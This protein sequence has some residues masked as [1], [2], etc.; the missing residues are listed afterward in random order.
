MQKAMSV[1]F[2]PGTRN[3]ITE[4][5]PSSASNV[6]L[7]YPSAPA[8]LN[9][10]IGFGDWVN[11]FRG[12]NPFIKNKMFVPIPFGSM[13]T[14]SCK[15]EY[16]AKKIN[17]DEVALNPFLYLSLRQVGAR[18]SDIELAICNKDIHS[19]Q[20]ASDAL[21]NLFLNLRMPATYALITQMEEGAK[22][23]KPQEMNG[24]FLAIKKSIARLV[25]YIDHLKIN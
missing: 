5:D 4:R 20:L 6:E 15:S 7:Y 13:Q 23:N 11:S 14:K 9:R 16:P 2:L 12:M 24:A 10:S 21:K 18:L 22:E 3:M 1:K 8:G 19:F 25:R 17:G